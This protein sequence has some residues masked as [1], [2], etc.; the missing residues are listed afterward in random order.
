MMTW[1]VGSADGAA[2]NTKGWANLGKLRS[3]PRWP[4]GPHMI[5][6]DDIRG[7]GTIN[8]PHHPKVQLGLSEGTPRS[9]K[10]QSSKKG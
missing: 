6:S 7:L 10:R 2:D 4:I 5:Q 1:Q 9:T 3:D 8:G